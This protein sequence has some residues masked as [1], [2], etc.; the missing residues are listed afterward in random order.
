MQIEF[1]SEKFSYLQNHRLY[2]TVVVPATTLLTLLHEF[3]SLEFDFALKNVTFHQPLYISTPSL[4]SMRITITRV[5]RQLRVTMCTEG[6]DDCILT[7]EIANN[8]MFNQIP[9]TDVGNAEI[10][11]EHE[12][13]Y[14]FMLQQGYLHSS[15]F[16]S[17]K[18]VKFSSRMG[19]KDHA[20]IRGVCAVI[21]NREHF[22]VVIDGVFQAI[23]FALLHSN[24]GEILGQKTE[25]KL[26]VPYFIERI[27]FGKRN[28]QIID[29]AQC[30]EGNAEFEKNL[31]FL[32][33][34]I[35]LLKHNF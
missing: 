1:A 32:K 13:F 35:T 4:S 3:T 2:G 12:A 21:S 31:A 14:S 23:V 16:R 18:A 8:D 22:D 11:F 33:E 25:K 34:L 24:A 26:L 17:V 5:D 15:Q 28:P 27:S 30:T 9:L 6:L 10:Q 29:D 7:A 20:R 19:E